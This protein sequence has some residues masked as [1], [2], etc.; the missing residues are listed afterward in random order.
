M[1]L[2][3]R[4]AGGMFEEQLLQKVENAKTSLTPM[5]S[6]IIYEDNRAAITVIQKGYSRSLAHI[7]RTHRVNVAWASEV[8]ANP[9]VNMEFIPT[10]H[11]AADIF[12]K[13]FTDKSAWRGLLELIGII[14][15]GTTN[16]GTRKDV[17]LATVSI[18]CQHESRIDM[19]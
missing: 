15:F 18:T 6:L 7:P 13:A 5:P 12:T 9:A 10:K 8:I 19:M 17:A 4:L 2:G 1:A 11:Q 14:E 3:D 16:V